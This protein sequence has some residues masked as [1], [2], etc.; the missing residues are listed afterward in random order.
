M[1]NQELKVTEILKFLKMA[2]PLVEKCYQLLAQDYPCELPID[3][4]NFIKSLTENFV[5]VPEWIEDELDCGETL[6]RFE[7]DD[8][9][10]GVLLEPADDNEFCYLP[11]CV[12][13]RLYDED[14]DISELYD[15]VD[16]EVNYAK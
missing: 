9:T 13:Q 3:N 11:D 4:E 1:K 16:Y 15:A 7:L 8:E 14:I 5:K 10:G 12:L 2:A 6:F